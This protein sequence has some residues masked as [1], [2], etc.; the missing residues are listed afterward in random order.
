MGQSTMPGCPS[1]GRSPCLPV[2]RLHF[3]LSLAGIALA[4]AVAIG[5]MFWFRWSLSLWWTEGMVLLTFW[6]VAAGV[7]L[8]KMRSPPLFEC[9]ACR[10]RFS[11]HAAGTPPVRS[12]AERPR[13]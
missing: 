1:C 11:L 13:Q 4:L 2:P 9:P 8:L 6:C 10:A 7:G 3:W 5:V 12:A